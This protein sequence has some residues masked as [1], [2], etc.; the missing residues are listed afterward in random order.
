MYLRHSN[1]WKE[2]VLQE[3]VE[4][5]GLPPEVAH[6]LRQQNEEH[7][8]VENKHLTWIGNLIK[9]VKSR[10]IYN[11]GTHQTIIED[12]IGRGG[13]PDTPEGEEAWANAVGFVNEW[14]IDHS[15]IRGLPGLADLKALKKSGRKMLKKRG[16]T[17]VMLRQW[18]SYLDNRM[19]R[20]ARSLKAYFVPI[21]QLLGEDPV[22]YD[23]LRAEVDKDTAQEPHRA[24]RAANNIAK[25]TLANPP[26]KEDQVIHTF[27]DGYYWYDLRKSYCEIEGREMKHCGSADKG[28]MYSLRTGE[29]RRDIKRYI[30]LSMDEDRTVYQI[31]AKG[32][33]APSE[34]LWPYLDAFIENA[35]VK[36]IAEVGMHSDDGI[37]F[38]EM[39]GHLKQKYG[40]EG[41][42]Q[43]KFDDS[44]VDEATELLEQYA[45]SFERDGQT[46]VDVSWPSVG[47]EEVQFT[48]KHQAFFP[49]K[50]VIVGE[51]T[52]RLRWEI[53]QDA[54][55]IVDETLYPNPR[56]RTVE[57]Y[58]RGKEDSRSAMLGISMAWEG[59]FF[60]DDEN[61]DDVKNE[62]ELLNSFL[63]EMSEIS[64]Y[65]VNSTAAPE[66][67]E[68][69]Y[70]EFY[71]RIEKRL[72]AYG[73]YRD[74]E[75]EIDAEDE[76]ERSFP[77]TR[78]MDLP[79]HEQR[80]IQRWSKLI[81]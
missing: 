74:L 60:A 70:N 28:T 56:I 80:I 16:A 51:D 9:A 43:V 67:A 48:L 71:E 21:M 25:E 18:D 2:Y 19:M 8:P 79:L 23:E 36:R 20:A 40:K 55:N 32:N 57:V 7:G 47:D 58:E 26:K 59:L 63:A 41:T 35:E 50:D 13:W 72:E 68:F 44:W 64:G 69:D 31:K 29:K 66:E 22:F 54:Q 77:S 14:Y 75:G 27:D 42:G 6:Y 30:T 17:D 78:Q 46:S 15:G 33:S 81:K 1:K 10:N 12:I 62:L 3:G 5:I 53:R 61:E 24:L 38:A 34:E 4:D 65:L 39:L 45:P 49:V 37:G 11:P 52:L 76:R 73:V